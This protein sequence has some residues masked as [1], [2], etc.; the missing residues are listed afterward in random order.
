MHDFEDAADRG[1]GREGIE[2]GDLE[3]V[4]VRDVRE[5]QAPLVGVGEM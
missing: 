5:E 4:F 3:R 1:L 2:R